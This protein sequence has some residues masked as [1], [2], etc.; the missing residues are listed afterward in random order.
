MTKDADNDRLS[1]T[2]GS[3]PSGFEVSLSG[4]TLSVSTTEGTA[5]GTTGEVTITG[6]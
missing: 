2:A 5:I 3:A 4:S 6:G 1:F